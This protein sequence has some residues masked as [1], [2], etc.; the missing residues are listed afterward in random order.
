MHYFIAKTQRKQRFRY[1]LLYMQIQAMSILISLIPRFLLYLFKIACF[2][3]FLVYNYKEVYFE[4]ITME[5]RLLGQIRA[6]V[7]SILYLT[8]CFI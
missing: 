8:A 1:I 7:L 2:L 3:S 5:S 4:Y 6:G